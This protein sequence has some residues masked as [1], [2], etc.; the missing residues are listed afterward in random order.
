[1]KHEKI[2]L[3]ILG[4]IAG[5]LSASFG[6]GGGVIFVPALYLLLNYEIKTVIGTSLAAIAPTAFVGAL[7]Y[8]I[9]GTVEFKL[10][11]ILFMIT[12][13]IAGAKL[14]AMAA[15]RMQS[16]I[17]LKIIAILFFT[18][19]LKLS[20]IVSMPLTSISITNSYMFLILLGFLAGSVSALF[21]IGSGVVIVSSL[22]LFFGMKSHE[23]IVISLS[24]VAP[25]TLAGAFFHKQFDNINL[26]AIKFLVPSALC[27]AVTGTIFASSLDADTLRIIFGIF[28][29]LIS[30]RFFF[31]KKNYTNNS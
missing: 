17:F 5:F 14:G 9:L 24:V 10:V 3:I 11:I 7:S 26:S 19:G 25:T 30:I 6:I 31:Q 28:L 21:G 29:I 15:N 16:N 22:I 8:Y 12:G 23:A 13:S 1:M 20:N 18:V 27:G 2:K 4:T